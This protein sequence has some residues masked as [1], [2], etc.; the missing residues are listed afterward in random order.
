MRNWMSAGDISWVITATALVML[1]T[2]ALGFFYGGLVRRKNLLSTIVQCFVI[3]AVISIVWAL[4]GYSLVFGPSIGGFIGFSP[5][6]LG[7]SSL[8]ISSVNTALA[9]NIP[10]LLYFAFQLKFAAITP[11]SSSAPAQ[12]AYASNPC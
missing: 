2:P 3:F 4:W 8:G 5:G 9:P 6:L 10:E 11:A 12:K 1:M 7:M